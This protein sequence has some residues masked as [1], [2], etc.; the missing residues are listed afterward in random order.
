MP[1]L[2]S[3][4]L[5][6]GTGGLALGIARAGFRHQLLA[7]IDRYALATLEEN[8]PRVAEMRDWPIVPKDV[9]EIDYGLSAGEVDLLAAGTPCQPFSLGGKHQGQNDARN[10]FPEVFRATRE[11][12]PR[13][14]LVEN[15][16]GLIRK[17]TKPYFEYILRRLTLPQRVPLEGEDWQAHDARLIKAIEIGIDT[18]DELRYEVHS[19]ILNV[20]DFGVPQRRERIF[21]VAF[22]DDL[23]ARPFEAEPTH[24]RDA[25]LHAQFVDGS[26]WREHGI[27]SQPVPATLSGRV[28]QLSK[29]PPPAELR[30]RTVRDALEGLPEPLDFQEHVLFANHAGKPGAR[31]YVGHTGS[32]MDEPAKTLKAGVHGVPGGE[33]MLRRADGSVR[34]FTLREAARLQTFPDEYRFSGPWSEIIRQLGNAVPVQMAEEVA[35]SIRCALEDAATGEPTVRENVRLQEPRVL[36]EGMRRVDGV[37][38]ALFDAILDRRSGSSLDPAQAPRLRKGPSR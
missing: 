3:I 1:I 9:A 32:P 4:E 26:Y 15:V 16:R 30:W 24:S 35:R 33:N 29:G 20:A 12:R 36:G 14:I 19:E 13:A 23:E 27:P 31:S 11:L 18:A 38:V 7:E 21:I 22:R 8:R 5:F 28:S 37:R 25:L 10:M 2:R 6:T 34:Y 17:A